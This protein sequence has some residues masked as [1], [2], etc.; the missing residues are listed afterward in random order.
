MKID[1]KKIKLVQ[2]V[3]KPKPIKEEEIVIDSIPNKEDLISKYTGGIEYT[4]YIFMKDTIRNMFYYIINSNDNDKEK[5]KSSLSINQFIKEYKFDREYHKKLREDTKPIFY[6]ILNVS[7]KFFRKHFIKTLIEIVEEVSTE[8]PTFTAY[9]NYIINEL[10]NII[11]FRKSSIIL[12]PK[13]N[14]DELHNMFMEIKEEFAEQFILGNKKLY[15]KY[16]FSLEP[17]DVLEDD[18]LYKVVY[19]IP[20]VLYSEKN[21]KLTKSNPRGIMAP[22]I[23]NKEGTPITA[24]FWDSIAVLNIKYNV[25]IP[26]KCLVP[27]DTYITNNKVI[28]MSNKVLINCF[29]NLK[30]FKEKLNR[31]ISLLLFSITETY[32][33]RRCL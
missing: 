24:K 33:N 15:S 26:V 14:F 29:S 11:N 9:K 20:K 7:S 1:L 3:P 30:M 13:T 8:S 25:E 18:V 17:F 10:H 22:V 16:D 23:F 32:Y 5:L 31:N 19:I 6:P 21:H 4:N 27:V 12:L 28:K 2:R